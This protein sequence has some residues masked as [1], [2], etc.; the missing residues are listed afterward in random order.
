MAQLVK[1]CFWVLRLLGCQAGLLNVLARAHASPTGAAPHA[2]PSASLPYVGMWQI[3]ARLV[4]VALMA[5]VAPRAPSWG[6][7]DFMVQVG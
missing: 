7:L 1:N 4:L 5:C 3:G 6:Q 2:G